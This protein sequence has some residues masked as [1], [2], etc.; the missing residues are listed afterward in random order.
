MCKDV[1]LTKSKNRTRFKWC[2]GKISKF[3]NSKDGLE[4]GVKPVVNKGIFNKT[5]TIKIP[6]QHFVLLKMS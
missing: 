2:K 4:W 3:I 6:V 5:I 1:A